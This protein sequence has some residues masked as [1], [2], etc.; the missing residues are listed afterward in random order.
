MLRTLMPRKARH[1]VPCD[2]ERASGAIKRLL[3]FFKQDQYE[4]QPERESNSGPPHDLKCGGPF[5]N[6]RNVQK[7][8][9]VVSQNRHRKVRRVV[10]L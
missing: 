2:P 8:R 6:Y 10:A 5:R 4:Q 7:A 3:A 9:L 1:T